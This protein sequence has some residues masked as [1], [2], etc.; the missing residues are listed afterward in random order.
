[1]LSPHTSLRNALILAE[2]IRST[3]QRL[4][5]TARENEFHVT[6]SVG[7]AA[8]P[9]AVADGSSLV[10]AADRALYQAKLQ[11]RNH[12]SSA[13]LTDASGHHLRAQ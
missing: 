9:E 5:F 2:R 10:D 13:A 8:T 12:V 4:P 7:V 3:I 11:G 1:M 6:V